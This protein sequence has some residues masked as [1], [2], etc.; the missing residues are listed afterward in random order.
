MTR[1]EGDGA[2]GVYVPA[3]LVVPSIRV[4]CTR[5]PPLAIVAYT[6]AIWIAVVATPWPNDSVYRVSAAHCDTGGSRPA[7]SPGSP[8][9]RGWPR[10]NARR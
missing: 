8:R 2:A 5:T 6:S 9:P 1:F 7:L 3:E 10:P 4:G